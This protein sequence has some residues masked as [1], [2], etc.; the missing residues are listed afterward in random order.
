MDTDRFIL[1]NPTEDIEIVN[2]HVLVNAAGDLDIG[3]RR[4][5][6]IP[7]GYHQ[8]LRFADF[9]SV[10]SVFERCKGG[11]ET[12]LETDA[13]KN[14]RLGHSLSAKACPLQCEIHWFFT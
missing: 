8:S 11:I 1:K 3:H 5:A 14:T 6:R 9:S 13:A 12:A 7:A 10:K 2:Q 4:R